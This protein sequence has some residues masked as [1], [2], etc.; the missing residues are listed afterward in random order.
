MF[1]QCKCRIWVNFSHCRYLCQ[2]V[3]V[4]VQ[5]CHTFLS[6]H[7]LMFARGH[8]SACTVCAHP[9]F[10]CWLSKRPYLALHSHFQKYTVHKLTP[11]SWA[12]MPWPRTAL[13]CVYFCLCVYECECVRLFIGRNY[14]KT[15]ITVCTVYLMYF[16]VCFAHLCVFCVHFVSMCVCD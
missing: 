13:V 8:L 2:T 10:N 7:M 3:A 11:C 12:Q 1:E 16:T 9:T 6:M 4:L 14:C 15:V 5:T